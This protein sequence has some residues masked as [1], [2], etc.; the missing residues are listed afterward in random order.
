MNRKIDHILS[1][2]ILYRYFD[3]RFTFKRNEQYVPTFEHRLVRDIIN[4]RNQKK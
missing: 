1:F 4:Q 2:K 3:E